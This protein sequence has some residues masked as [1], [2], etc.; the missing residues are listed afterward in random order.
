MHL[1]SKKQ[2][3]SLLIIFKILNQDLRANSSLKRNVI[4]FNKDDLIFVEI[5][6][7]HPSKTKFSEFMVKIKKFI[8]L[9]ENSGILDINEHII[10]PV[11]IY[12]ENYILKTNETYSFKK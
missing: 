6:F 12:D 1:L 10:K 7:T 11:F 4:K 2:L 8:K 3:I 5:C 9:Y